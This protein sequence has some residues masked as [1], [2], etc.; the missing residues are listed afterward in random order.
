[1]LRS[2]FR[3]MRGSR[4]AALAGGLVAGLLVMSAAWAMRVSPMVS[5]LTTTGAGSAARIEVGNVGSAA[6]PFETLITRMDI[7]A[8][9]NI[10]E[11][12]AD[13]DFLVFPPQGL[14][15]VGG[16]QVVRVQWVGEP[17]IESSSAYY[18]WVKQ[19]PVQVDPT[20]PDSGGS[21]S[22]QVLYTMKALIVVAPPGAQPKVEVLSAV[23]AMVTPPEPEVDPSLS[24]GEASPPP[25]AQPG[26]EIVV[27]NT[28][29]RYALMSG[30]TWIMEGTDKAGQ[31]FHREFTGDEISQ[32][33]GVGYLAPLGGKR[34]FK[35]P[36]GVEL[37]PAK[38][39]SVRFAR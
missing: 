6:L 36:T 22:V 10:V 32:I 17:T 3:F 26:V 28:G 30:A 19:L 27:A 7:D 35:V 4:L 16:R 23:P 37:D 25:P 29:K 18:L 20:T 21:L 2:D 13:E 12:P 34:T 11:T 9:G 15:P 38:P 31:P 39:V 5:E 14:V 1:M 24:G 8:D 33:V